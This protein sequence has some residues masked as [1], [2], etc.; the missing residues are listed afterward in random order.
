MV[1][2]VGRDR[3]DQDVRGEVQ[4]D[5]DQDRVDQVDLDRVDQEQQ[6]VGLLWLLKGEVH[7][8]PPV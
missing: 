8:H 2:Q 3:V 7:S 6:V 4:L 5:I 1:D